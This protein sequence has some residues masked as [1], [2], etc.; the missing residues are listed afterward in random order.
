MKTW[1]R[2]AFF[3][4]FLEG[5]PL[6]VARPKNRGGDTELKSDMPVIGTACGPIVLYARQGR[7]M[8]VNA[9]ETAQMDVRVRYF[10]F[11]RQI[12]A[13]RLVHNVRSCVHCA[14]RLYLEGRHELAAGRQRSRSPRRQA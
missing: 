11:E 5:L 14:A 1:T 7:T 8:V 4:N 10:R 6:P 2:W 3:K 12:P 13:D 9:S